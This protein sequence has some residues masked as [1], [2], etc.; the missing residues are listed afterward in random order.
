MMT[1][2]LLTHL[3]W[4]IA[5]GMIFTLMLIRRA[6]A[7]KTRWY[8]NHRERINARC[9]NFIILEVSVI[10]IFFYTG[11]LYTLLISS[12]QPFGWIFLLSAFVLSL[13]DWMCR[14]LSWT[15]AHK[16]IAELLCILLILAGIKLPD[17]LAL[18]VCLDTLLTMTRYV[19]KDILE[20]TRSLMCQRKDSRPA[21]AVAW[22][23]IIGISMVAGLILLCFGWNKGTKGVT[24]LLV[25]FIFFWAVVHGGTKDNNDD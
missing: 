17:L 25:L 9:Y 19:R 2:A 8:K 11:L 1:Q 13:R 14:I 18:S 7:K 12:S 15:D 24:I 21:I 10:G 20:Q 5:F 22:Y 6:A 3:Q 4:T 23:I 16:V